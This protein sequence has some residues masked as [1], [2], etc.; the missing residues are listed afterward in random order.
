MSLHLQTGKITELGKGM[1][2]EGEVCGGVNPFLS[3]RLGPS[4]AEVTEEEFL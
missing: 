1:S 3:S 2:K 4:L